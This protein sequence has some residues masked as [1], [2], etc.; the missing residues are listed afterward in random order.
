MK[1]YQAIAVL[2]VVLTVAAVAYEG[3]G[4]DSNN[5]GEQSRP[6]A[7][8]ALAPAKT[9]PG[10]PAMTQA[11]APA[12]RIVEDHPR[13]VF[14]DRRPLV[15]EVQAIAQA[16]RPT[17]D[18]L[19]AVAIT[20]AA[21]FG[22]PM[23]AMTVDAPI[24][25]TAQGGVEWDQSVECPWNG[26]RMR[27]SAASP[28][29]LHGI[30]IFPEMGW[31]IAPGPLDPFDPCPAAPMSSPR[32]YLEFVAR[33]AR[34]NARVISYRDRP[35]IVAQANEQQRRRP[36]GP[37]GTTSHHGGELLIGYALQG[38]EM[39]ETLVVAMTR[40]PLAGGARAANTRITLAIRSPD[41]LLD[42]GFAERV[43][44]SLRLD[45]A[46][47]ARRS[48]WAMAKWREA[49]ERAT[50]SIDAWHQRRM[51]EINLAGMTARHQI[52]MD[53]IAEIGRINN[54]IVA[55]TS[56]SN[57]RMHAATIDAIHE[58]QPWRDPTSGKQVD[59]SIHYNHAWQ[60]ADGRQF[61]TNDSGFDPNR[62]LNI[63]GHRLE[64]VR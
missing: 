63:S 26:P 57:E 46:W 11:P 51:R 58:V 40:T 17:A 53:T 34:P 56:A 7:Q 6:L 55:N 42:F 8:A 16:S 32:E 20:D 3:S 52:R 62:E 2:A 30:D 25:W 5:A 39:R 28:D 47:F 4:G 24:G 21:G 29:G 22:R 27:W 38:H 41:G 13:G 60:L 36:P 33:Q 45:E 54:R 19:Q 18:R 35:D 50:R 31:Q 1:T 43:R 15:R 49:G 44:S 12:A 14:F 10:V 48:Q 23:T 9:P 64:P 59:L 61:L 37:L